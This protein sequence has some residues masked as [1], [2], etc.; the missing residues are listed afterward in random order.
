[1]F[2]E[3]KSIDSSIIDTLKPG[4]SERER[5]KEREGRN[6][7]AYQ[8]KDLLRQFYAWKLVMT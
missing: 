2:P 1:M 3:R 5:E 4:E 7:G 8:G 6:F